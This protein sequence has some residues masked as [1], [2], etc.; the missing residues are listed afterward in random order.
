MIS[1]HDDEIKG[2]KKKL[3]NECPMKNEDG[4]ILITIL[5]SHQVINNSLHTIIAMILHTHINMIEY[6]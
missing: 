6:L 2:A 1:D 4:I 5:N 3:K